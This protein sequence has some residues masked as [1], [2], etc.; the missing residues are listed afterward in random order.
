M[1]Y[2][3]MKTAI[4]TLLAFLPLCLCAQEY[5][6]AKKIGGNTLYFYITSTGGKNGPTVEV[7]YPGNSEEEPWKGFRKPSGQ[8]VIPDVVTPDRSR[9]RNANPDDDDTTLYTVTAIRYFAFAGCD[10]ITRLTL[11]ATIKEIGEGAF[12]GCKRIEYIV[13]QNPEPPKLDESS[14]DQVDLDIPVRVPM[15]TYETYHQAVGWRQFT[16]IT[17]Y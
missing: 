15:A 10:R 17:E 14:F 16:E 5:D 6:F 3:A 4:L 9:G 8:L 13:S 7:T 2:P 11:P 1:R 12:A